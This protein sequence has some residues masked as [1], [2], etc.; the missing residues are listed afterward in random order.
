[1]RR[2]SFARRRTARL[3]TRT[4]GGLMFDPADEGRAAAHA[5]ALL[6]VRRRR[7][8]NLASASAILAAVLTL[9]APSPITA[10]ESV[11][12]PR[13]LATREVSLSAEAQAAVS[14]VLGTMRTGRGSADSSLI[15]LAREVS[16]TPDVVTRALLETR[17]G[18]D[19]RARELLREHSDRVRAL[20]STPRERGAAGPSVETEA[21]LAELIEALD[22]SAGE[23]R[24]DTRETRLLALME[25]I[26]SG[27]LP[28]A[29]STPPTRTPTFV[30]VVGET[31]ARAPDSGSDGSAE[32]P[33][34]AR[35][36]SE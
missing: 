33:I 16:R 28:V 15:L 34:S 17:A 30:W 12:S 29:P 1:M 14:V 32:E 36:D 8:P 31:D 23:A 20:H 9:A 5:A 22:E 26:R 19:E 21:Y 27:S 13:A 25:R 6:Q 24:R 4:S 7:P 11:P 2:G 10:Q 3:G 18:H 35:A